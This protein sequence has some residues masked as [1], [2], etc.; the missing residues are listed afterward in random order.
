LVTNRNLNTKRHDGTWF[1]LYNKIF[2][3]KNTTQIDFEL[4]FRCCQRESECAHERAKNVFIIVVVGSVVRFLQCLRQRVD[5]V[6][7]GA[8]KLERTNTSGGTNVFREKKLVHNTKKIITPKAR[9]NNVLGTSNTGETVLAAG[10]LALRAGAAVVGTAG[11][12][13]EHLRVERRVGGNVVD[14][15]VEEAERRFA[16]GDTQAIEQRDHRRKHWRRRRRAR[17]LILVAAHS[18]KVAR[19]RISTIVAT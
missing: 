10:G 6:F 18:Y 5:K 12:V 2:H 16:L 19:A 4:V 7:L 8:L 13:V 1:I 17:A 9:R 3:N 15:L 11:D 14:C